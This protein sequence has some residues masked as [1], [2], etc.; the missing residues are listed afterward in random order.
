MN[1]FINI[2]ILINKNNS[3]K[4]ISVLI[5]NIL[6]IISLITFVAYKS[7]SNIVYLELFLKD[8]SVYSY[9]NKNTL[10]VISKT[11]N[12]IINNKKYKYKLKIEE[13]YSY[14]DNVL[15]LVLFKIKD[16]KLKDK[17]TNANIEDKNDYFI[18][19]IIN[20]IKEDVWKN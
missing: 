4:I 17:I 3:M 12:I 19:R 1:E 14:N 11:N 18:K 6:I 16:V 7:T 9:V 13:E 5:L 10:K 8:E 15:I 2:D 20:I